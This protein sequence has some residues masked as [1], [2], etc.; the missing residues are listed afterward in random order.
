MYAKIINNAVVKYPFTTQDLIEENPYSI[1]PFNTDILTVYGQTETAIR[2]GASIVE[3]LSRG[4]PP[5]NVATQKVVEGTPGLE[6]NVWIQ[7]WVVQQLTQEET[8]AITTEKQIEI[9]KLRNDLL[10]DSDWTQV[11]DA[12]I[13][14]DEWATYRQQLRDIPLQ[15]GFPFSVVWPTEPQ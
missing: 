8:Q 9:R 11:L 2:D 4:I 1:F 5:Y 3:V 10:K 15:Q 6:N 7:T 13:N 14:K 12:P